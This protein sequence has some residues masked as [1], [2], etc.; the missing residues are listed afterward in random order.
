[1]FD[2]R[3]RLLFFACLKDAAP[4]PGSDQQK[5]RL[6]CRP[7]SG[8]SRRLRLRNTGAGWVLP[9]GV[10]TRLAAV[11]GS[12]WLDW[13]PLTTTIL[14]VFLP[15]TMRYI[16]YILNSFCPLEINYIRLKGWEGWDQIRIRIKLPDTTPRL[17]MNVKK[18]TLLCRITHN[19][20]AP[21]GSCCTFVANP[22]GPIQ[23]CL[24]PEFFSPWCWFDPHNAFLFVVTNIQ[25]FY[26]KI[27]FTLKSRFPIRNMIRLPLMRI[28]YGTKYPHAVTGIGCSK[29]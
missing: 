27:T 2:T 17:E 15:T 4:A 12:S 11:T 19:L 24:D 18:E 20:C 1:M 28:R 22:V 25:F 10:E 16:P 6:R 5:N 3:T 21:K 29:L 7:K 8:S 23:T 13:T 9:V 14:L 26:I